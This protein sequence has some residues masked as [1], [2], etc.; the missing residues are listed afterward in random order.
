MH[1][2][3]HQLNLPHH[4]P[5][6][7]QRLKYMNRDSHHLSLSVKFCSDIFGWYRKNKKFKLHIPLKECCA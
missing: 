5:Q 4:Y 7:D 6:Q 2:F 3:T 1:F